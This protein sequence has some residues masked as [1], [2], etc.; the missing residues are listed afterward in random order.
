MIHEPNLGRVGP[1]ALI[2]D[3][4]QHRCAPLAPVDVVDVQ[5]QGVGRGRLVGALDAQKLLPRL[6]PVAVLLVLRKLPIVAG[7]IGALV[8]FEHFLPCL[9]WLLGLGGFELLGYSGL[10]LSDFNMGS[11][12]HNCCRALSSV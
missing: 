10:R 2:T 1:R 8:A 4:G 12:A 11:N 6:C 3:K 5:G 7:L 9:W